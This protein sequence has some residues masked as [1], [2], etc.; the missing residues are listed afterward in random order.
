MAKFWITIAVLFSL[1]AQSAMVNAMPTSASTS[2][3]SGQ[4]ILVMDAEMNCTMPDCSTSDC[5]QYCQ[6]S[7]TSHCQTHCVSSLYIEPA[8]L[9]LTF[10][11]PASKR[12]AIQGW[13]MKTADLGLI[14]QPPIHCNVFRF[15][16]RKTD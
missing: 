13:A 12:I 7:M 16:Q 3:R 14:T 9:E 15:F 5:L 6:D 4:I 10:A 2:G 11:N 8:V 1:I